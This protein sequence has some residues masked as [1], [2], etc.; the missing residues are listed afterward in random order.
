MTIES[1]QRIKKQMSEIRFVSLEKYDMGMAFTMLIRD[2]RPK[3]LCRTLCRS[4]LSMLLTRN[5]FYD[6]DRLKKADMLFFYSYNYIDRTDHM[7]SFR[8]MSEIPQS[9]NLLI[10]QR[11]KRRFSAKNL[12]VL[13]RIPVWL[14]QIRKIDTDRSN[15]TGMVLV[16]A[17]LLTWAG[18][19]EKHSGALLDHKAMVTLFDAD[20]Y[21][22]ILV[23]F[24]RLHGIPTA[25]FQ[26][27]HFNASS[28]REN[29]FEEIGA[30]FEGFVSDRFLAWGEYTKN[31]AIRNG[32]DPA[33]ILCTGSAKFIGYEGTGPS[34][35]AGKV[36]GIVMNGIGVLNETMNI[37][38]IRTANEVAE[39]RNMKYLLKPHPASDMS[40]FESIIKEEYLQG[41]TKKGGAIEEYAAAVDFSIA[42]GSSVY[43]ELIYMG[44]IV[45]RFVLD[46]VIDR[47]ENIRSGIVKNSEDLV[48]MID[49]Y[50]RDPE[51][52][53][54]MNAEIKSVLYEPGDVRENYRKAFEEL[55]R[56]NTA[57][58]KY[59]NG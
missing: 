55:I 21:E 37:D 38:M 46:G 2:I 15:R 18:E 30:A 31:E 43:S 26:H 39:K 59:V 33:K 22:S 5:W 51:S 53:H 14:H 10:G 3:I 36:F 11:N 42:M 50:N 20:V 6:F 1:F 52:I 49:L 47:Y 28:K 17:N 23:Q 24:F 45:F 27:G 25:T 58:G 57:K 34:T 8:K 12:G 54:Q 40:K 29:G 7:N 44:Q 56:M 41:V 32:V 13:C 16:M 4:F 48:G 35:H 9:R 19:I